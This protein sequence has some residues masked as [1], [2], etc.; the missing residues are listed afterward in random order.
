MRVGAI[1]IYFCKYWKTDAIFYQ[2]SLD[3][4][5]NTTW[6]LISKLIAWKAEYDEVAI[7]VLFI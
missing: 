6:L 7:F 4:F 5:F 3:D 1:D 2:A